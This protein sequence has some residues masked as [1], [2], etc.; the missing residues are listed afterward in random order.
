M[1]N[2]LDK[3]LVAHLGRQAQAWWRFKFTLPRLTEI[4]L[5]G[6]RLDVSSLSPRM[7]NNLLE[8]RYEVQERKFAKEFLKPDDTV[9]EIGGAIGFIGLF[10]QT[11]LNIE[12]YVTVEANPETAK[13]LERNYALNGRKPDL[14]NVALANV[15]GE[16]ALNIGD[17]FWENSVVSTN[18]SATARTVMV[19]SLTF[20]SLLAK[21]PFPINTLIID[22]EGAEQFIDFQRTP[23]SVR[24]I[25]VE[26][27]PNF[28]GHP[29]TYRI[30]A[31]LVNLGFSV[32]REEG[33]TYF[34]RRS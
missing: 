9:L 13:L 20:D 15:D 17:E 26:L 6:V 10:C 16:I 12:H 24:K 2:L 3:S 25:I 4:Q 33:G 23:A 11:Q 19:P 22:I 27:H 32:E 8:G 1:K 7:R 18:A 21:L 34:F 31:D 5:E 29:A 14:W 30:V 28:I